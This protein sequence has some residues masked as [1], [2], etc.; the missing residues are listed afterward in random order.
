MASI[1]TM[2]INGDIPGHFVYRD[3]QCV[4]FMSI[5]P[6][7][8]GHTLVVPIEEVDH[9][10]DLDPDLIAH[11]M[12]VAQRVGQAIDALYSPRRVGLLIVGD[13]VPHVHIHVTPIDSARDLDFVNAGSAT[14]EELAVVAERLRNALG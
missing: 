10:I 12:K 4:A 5:E 13:E 8:D 1:F 9:W 3:D 7:T 11:L 6:L 2:I 14:S